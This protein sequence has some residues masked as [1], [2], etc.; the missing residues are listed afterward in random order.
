MIYIDFQGGSH[1]NYLEFVCNK[2]AG[3]KSNELPFNQYGASHTKKYQDNK[4]FEATHYSYD[5]GGPMESNAK[6]I[7]IYITPTDLLPLT[8]ISL[9]R[10]GDF[11]YYNDELEIK[12]YH[13]LSISNYKSLL[14]MLNKNFFTGQIARSYNNV[15]N[16]KW[17]NVATMEDFEALPAWIKDECL[18]VHKL[19]LLPEL[20]KTNPNCPRYILREMFKIGFKDPTNTGFISNQNNVKYNNGHDVFYFPFA[21]FYDT[22]WFIKE[23]QAVATW[24]NIPYN[25]ISE[26]H[27]EFLERQPYKNSKT[28]CDNLLDR[29]LNKEIFNLP[30]I[31][32][33]QESYISAQ[34]ELKFNKEIPDMMTTWFCTSKEIIDYF[35]I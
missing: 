34:L 35:E 11:Q 17:P 15:K 32:L 21:C 6:I 8:S 26:L 12:T 5:L 13:K 22:K 25:D 30:V 2:L 24:A 23:I 28:V 19:V 7:S 33:L 4:I 14:D 29:I 20:S 27:K 9:L 16:E 10:A 18:N 31:D 3:I 1:G